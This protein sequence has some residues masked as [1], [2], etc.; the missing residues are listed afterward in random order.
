MLTAKDSEIDKVVGLELGADDYVT[1]PYS[2]RE[3]LARIKAVLRRNSGEQSQYDENQEYDY[4]EDVEDDE[5]MYAHR[6]DNI[7]DFSFRQLEQV[8]ARDDDLDMPLGTT[9]EKG[10]L[11]D[12][13][14]RH[15]LMNLDQFMI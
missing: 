4:G 13:M 10:A 7:V 14:R 6:E 8:Q 9:V 15:E 1:K 12:I 5:D 2:S 11:A 3:L